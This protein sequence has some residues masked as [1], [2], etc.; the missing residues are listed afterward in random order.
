MKKISGKD[1]TREIYGLK[2]MRFENADKN[3]S[4]TLKYS[5]SWKTLH[6]I[7]NYCIGPIDLP[8]L[9]IRDEDIGREVSAMSM[10]MKIFD[11]NLSVF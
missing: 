9:L 3:Y 2:S 8:K 10:D 11:N 4:K 1:I 7:T 6:Y 5:H